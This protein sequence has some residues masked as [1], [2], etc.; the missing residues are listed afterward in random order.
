[1]LRTL[2]L[3]FAL[4]AIAPFSALARPVPEGFTE[5]TKRLTPSVVNISTAQT[6][7]IDTDEAPTFPKGSP[8]ERF[9]DFFGQ[10]NDRDGRVSKSLGSG[11]VIDREGHIVTNNHVIEDA[12]LIE[13]TFS[14]GDTY[15]AELIG[16]DPATDIAVLKIDTG[17]DMP[18]VSFGDSDKAEV[19]EWVIAIGN[20]FGYSGSVAAGI[21]SARNRNISHGSYDDFIQTDVAINRGNSGGPLFNMQG[22]VIGVNTAILSPTGYSVGISFS[23]PAELAESVVEQ[24]VEY[25]ETRRGYLGV[26]PQKVSPTLAK[27]YGLEETFGALVTAVIADS[28]A[29]KAG[30]QKGDLITEIG[31]ELLES[32]RL[33]SRKIAD[34]PINKPLE[35][36]YIRKRKERT[37]SVLIERLKEEVT[38]EEKARREQEESEADRSVN[39]IYVEA[40]SDEVRAKYRIDSVVKGVRVVR[41]DKHAEASGKILVGDIIEEVGFE[42][43]DT[44]KAFE[45][46]VEASK[47]FDSP[48]TFLINRGGNYIFYALNVTS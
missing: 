34:A 35:I 18:F 16:R 31:G 47:Q 27:S 45:E 30:L 41:V 42:A 19:G 46:G 33:L 39:G 1:M 26:R 17:K 43:I 29:D 11:F 8:L 48:V 24:L 21:I 14:N 36:K 25:G 5:L 15:E 22:E 44:P 32:S 9:N 13:V 38:E 20:P 3:S 37:A 6:I 10:G 28:P 2:I 4:I 40:L 23:V 7:E 12:D